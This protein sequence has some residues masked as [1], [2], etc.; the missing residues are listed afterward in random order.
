MSGRRS[1]KQRL[2]ATLAREIATISTGEP[3]TLRQRILSSLLK[4]VDADAA[5][6]YCLGTAKGRRYTRCWESAGSQFPGLMSNLSTSRADAAMNDTS[7]RDFAR[8]SR[9]ERSSFVEDGALWKPEV[10]LECR[11]Y[12]TILAPFGL[13]HQ[14]RLLAYHG[15]R[16]LGWVGL[17]RSH[18][19]KPF[20]YH[21]RSRLQPLVQPVITALLTAERLENAALPEEA[22]DIILSASG[23][24]AHATSHG[25]A[26]L[27]HPGFAT[28]LAAAV[29]AMD[30]D[31]T[32]A[33]EHL[34]VGPAQVRMVRVDGADGVRY[35]AQVGPLTALT[36]H[37]DTPLTPTQRKIAYYLAA[38]AT[39]KE[40]ADALG[41]SAE[42]VRTH[43]RTIYRRLVVSSRVELARA[44]GSETPQ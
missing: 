24:V 26:W 17:V 40:A 34:G 41:V 7:V 23:R 21:D 29:R 37:P 42:T 20:T 6:F 44:L 4:L 15:N 5:C 30:R 43:L 2:A 19:T 16:F 27:A 35:L 33:E 11:P 38:G 18:G 22:G 9:L 1:A 36:M 8:P 31:E 39:V 3:H 10:Y 13:R 32:S 25:Q 14:Q 12:R 28:R